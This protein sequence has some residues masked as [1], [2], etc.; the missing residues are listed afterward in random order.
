M[1]TRLFG[2][3]SNRRSRRENSFRPQIEV[4]ETRNLL[5]PVAAPPPPATVL[6]PV[7][8]LQVHSTVLFF[9]AATGASANTLKDELKAVKEDFKSLPD[10]KNLSLSEMGGLFIAGAEVSGA[11]AVLVARGQLDSSVAKLALDIMAQGVQVTGAGIMSTLGVPLGLVQFEQKSFDSN[12]SMPT[13]LKTQGD[14]I[15]NLIKKAIYDLVTAV[16]DST[17]DTALAAEFTP[18]PP[19]S[20]PHSPPPPAN[21]DP[22][23]DGDVDM[24]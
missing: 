23:H 2:S 18:G 21:H 19:P 4:L 5:S 3:P 12:P 13:P 11:G 17:S 8:Q 22:D 10:L 7:Q 14:S 16:A 24:Y 6:P 9:S 20:P 15:F 1:F